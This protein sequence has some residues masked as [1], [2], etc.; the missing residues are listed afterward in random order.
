MLLCFIKYIT[1]YITV[2]KIGVQK[3]SEWLVHSPY[4]RW[5]AKPTPRLIHM[6]RLKDFNPSLAC[7][8][9]YVN[10]FK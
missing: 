6:R 8:N 7:Y 3:D 4:G 10:G 2:L 1:S 5:M 9:L